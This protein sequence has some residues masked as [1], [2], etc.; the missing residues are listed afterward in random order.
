VFTEIW[1]I[2]EALKQA[3]QQCEQNAISISFMGTSSDLSKKNL[4]QLSPTF[5]YTQTL[6]EILLSIEFNEE[7]I[8]EFIDYCRGVF[9][10]NESELKN[11]DGVQKRYHNKT[12]IS[13]YMC[14]CFLY[15]MLNS[16]LR[17]MDVNVIIKMGFFISNLHCHIEQLHS[18]QFGDRPSGNSF[19]VYRGQGMSKTDFNQMTKTKGGLMSFNNFLLTSRDRNASVDFACGALPNSDMVGILFVMTIDPA[20]STTPLASIAQR[21]LSQRCRK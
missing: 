3:A 4:D 13:W 16:A 18:K 9:A 14:K 21:E 5:M 2:C 20:K 15:P 8:K 6:K 19:T 1:P 17:L 10:E 12:P 11:V 7:H